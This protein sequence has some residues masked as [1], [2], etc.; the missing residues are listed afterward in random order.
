LAELVEP[1]LEEM[2]E[3]VELFLP[4]VQQMQQQLEQQVMRYKL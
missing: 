4:L 2:V 3:A 1:A